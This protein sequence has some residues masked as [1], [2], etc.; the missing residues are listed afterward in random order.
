VPADTPHTAG[1]EFLIVLFVIFCLPP[2]ELLGV[3]D[4]LEDERKG[5][6]AEG[7]VVTE[8]KAGMG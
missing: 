1:D 6:K 2:S 3:G 4:D 8:T 7:C 5:E